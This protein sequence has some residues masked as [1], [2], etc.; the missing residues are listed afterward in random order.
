M[1]T[2]DQLPRFVFVSANYDKE[3]DAK[4]NVQYAAISKACT[5]LNKS[6][7]ISINRIKSGTNIMRILCTRRMR[8]YIYIYVRK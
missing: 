3:I 8:L 1:R 2:V 5:W 6:V 7:K 4:L